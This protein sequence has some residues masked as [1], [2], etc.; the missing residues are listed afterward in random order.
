MDVDKI[1]KF[2]DDKMKLIGKTMLQPIFPADIDKEDFQISKLVRIAQM[3]RTRA[4]QEVARGSIGYNAYKGGTGI[5]TVYANC[6]GAFGLT[7][8]PDDDCEIYYADPAD[9]HTYI[10]LDQYFSHLKEVRTAEMQA[11]AEDLGAKHYKIIYAEKSE[12]AIV[13][14]AV[15]TTDNVSLEIVA[16]ASLSGGEPI[17]PY[18]KYLKNEAGIRALIETRFNRAEPLEPQKLVLDFASSQ[19]IT[20][21]EAVSIDSALKAIKLAGNITMQS[22][23][24]KE[25]RNYFEFELEF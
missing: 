17:W 21:K 7:L 15:N 6:I 23:V 8:I 16:D 2:V 11:V 14:A 4:E 5:T 9:D 19:G 1:S 10:A 13:N 25:E 20:V 22:L 3:D 12:A 18:L 24:E